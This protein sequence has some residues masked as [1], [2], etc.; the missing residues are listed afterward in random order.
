MNIGYTSRVMKNFG[1][2]NLLLVSPKANLEEAYRYASHGNDIVRAAKL[3]SLNDIVQRF[4][5]IVGTTAIAALRPSNIVRSTLTPSKMREK[6]QDVAGKVCLLLGRDTTGLTNTELSVCDFVVTIPTRTNYRALNI[7]HAAAILLW[8]LLGV[9]E[10]A[11][12]NRSPKTTR[13][14][15]KIEKELV[16]HKAVELA[17][18]S[19][20][21]KH[22]IPLMAGAFRHILGKAASS[23][24]ECTLVLALLNKSVVMMKKNRA[25]SQAFSKT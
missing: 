16:V 13:P 11:K 24:R 14:A 5:I 22:K 4:D 2:K 7:S 9:A 21:P 25:A 18:T 20:F 3:C 8:E 12:R 23:S 10:N 1:V 15:S 17:K 6:L 19:G